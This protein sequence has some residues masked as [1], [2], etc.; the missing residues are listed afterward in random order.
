MAGNLGN[1]ER[2]VYY[3]HM[4]HGPMI[5]VAVIGVAGYGILRAVE[6]GATVAIKRIQAANQLEE[7]KPDD[8]LPDPE[9]QTT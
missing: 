5:F 1:Y 2:I 6:F 9:E 7:D 3:S 8:A 4:M